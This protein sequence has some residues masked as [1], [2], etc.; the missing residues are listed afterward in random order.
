MNKNVFE[1]SVYKIL[2]QRALNAFNLYMTL[3]LLY[4]QLDFF[5]FASLERKGWSWKASFCLDTRRI[6]YCNCH[7]GT[8]WTFKRPRGKLPR[9]CQTIQENS[10]KNRCYIKQHKAR[11]PR[12]VRCARPRRHFSIF[13]D[14]LKF[15]KSVAFVCCKFVM[16]LAIRTFKH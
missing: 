11:G 9:N 8:T 14:K 5:L 4:S 6:H 3:L 16:R 15:V 2:Q 10:R 7:H 1:T 13:H 12:P